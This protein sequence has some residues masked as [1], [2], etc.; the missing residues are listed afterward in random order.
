MTFTHSTLQVGEVRLVDG[1]FIC[2]LPPATAPPPPG[3]VGVVWDVSQQM[4]QLSILMLMDLGT[5]KGHVFKV[6]GGGRKCGGWREE[7]GQAYSQSL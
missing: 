3:G 6:T 7:M 1:R 4:T 2:R 5:L